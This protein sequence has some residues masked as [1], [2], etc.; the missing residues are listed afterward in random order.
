[1]DILSEIESNARSR[2]IPVILPD[3]RAFLEELCLSLKPKRILEIGMAVGYSASVMLRATD[4]SITC[5]E[6][7]VPNIKEARQNFEKQG[8]SN[9]VNIVEGD[10]VVTLPKLN[11]K[12][13]LIFLDGPKGKY[14]ELI[15]LI[16]PLLSEN[17][18]WVS[19]NV[20]FRGMVLDGKA[21]S[22]PRFNHTVEVLRCFIDNLEK[23]E[24]LDT[25]VY[26]IGDGLCVVKY[27]GK[28]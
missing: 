14:V 28:K 15:P 16:L 10:C 1:V 12:F 23:N 22:E 25:R 18:V 26:H 20:L 5:L 6:A 19:D 21:I 2:K 3:T 13:D 17:G 27:K 11:E 7:S 24:K 4:A 9:R 8:L